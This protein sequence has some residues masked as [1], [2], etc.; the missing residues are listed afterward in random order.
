M[1][2][3]V[4]FRVDRPPLPADVAMARAEAGHTQAQA[5]AVVHRAGYVTWQRWELGTTPMPLD[6]WELYLLKTGQ[7]PTH[8]LQRQR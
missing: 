5:S 2:S 1:S 4:E 3:V 8:R 6:C 7:H